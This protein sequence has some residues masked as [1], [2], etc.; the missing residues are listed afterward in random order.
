MRF[1][2]VTSITYPSNV[3]MYYILMGVQILYALN[4]LFD[5]SSF[6]HESDIQMYEM[7]HD[8]SPETRS[9]GCYRRVL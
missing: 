8:Y 5:L 6:E 4:D 1:E 2:N 3:A 7:I 9:R